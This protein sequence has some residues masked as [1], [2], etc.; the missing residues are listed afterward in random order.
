MDRPH[1]HESLVTV[2]AAL[3]FPDDLSVPKISIGWISR[4]FLAIISGFPTRPVSNVF[5]V[6]D[7][8][9]PRYILLLFISV[10]DPTKNRTSTKK[11]VA[12]D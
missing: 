8:L 2:F 3:T 4:S 5:N 12:V 1:I 7:R 6:P 10:M 11:N 9:I